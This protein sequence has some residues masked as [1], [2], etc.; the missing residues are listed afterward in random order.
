MSPIDDP[1]PRVPPNAWKCF[2]PSVLST[3]KLPILTT[4]PSRD[5]L[6]VLNS[7]RS[8]LG[9]ALPIDQLAALLW[10]AVGTKGHAPKGRASIPIEW[11]SSPSAGGLHP[12][13]VVCIPAPPD[14]EVLLY[15]APTH[16]LGTLQLNDHGI[17]RLNA[18]E[19]LNVVG[20][21]RGW[22]L[23]FIADID[24]IDAAYKNPTS[25][26]LRDSGCLLATICLCAEWLGLT[27]CPLGFLGQALC[28]PLGFPSERFMGVGGVQVASRN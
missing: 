22:T 8:S 28:D 16:S 17:V 11:R 27:A 6:D 9:G 13:H 23:R 3:L 7:R 26:A 18:D 5:F 14:D 12:I 15:D 21:S 10:Y 1:K 4:G 19:V 2:R 20:E 24:K 25:L